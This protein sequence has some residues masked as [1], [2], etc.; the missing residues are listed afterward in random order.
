M[1]PRFQD[2]HDLRRFEKCERENKIEISR[3]DENGG[4]K[5]SFARVMCK[6]YAIKFRQNFLNNEKREK[7]VRVRERSCGGGV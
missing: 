6:L 2:E 7:R 4:K 5:R 3:H 1:D